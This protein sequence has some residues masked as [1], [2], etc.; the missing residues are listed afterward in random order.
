[1][2]DA[3]ALEF[4]R[5]F[6]GRWARTRN[7]PASLAGAVRELRQRGVHPYGWAPWVLV[8]RS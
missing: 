5:A 3:S 4:S 2:D 6:Q 1:V 8:S 7:A